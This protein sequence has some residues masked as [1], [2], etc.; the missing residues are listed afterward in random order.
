MTLCIRPH[1]PMA[2][3]QGDM[4]L[5]LC[6]PAVPV[7]LGSVAKVMAQRLSRVAGV[8]SLASVGV[9]VATDCA[10]NRLLTEPRIGDAIEFRRS[11]GKVFQSSISGI[12]TV[13]GD[14][15]NVPFDF[16]LPRGAAKEDVGTGDEIWL[17]A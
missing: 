17:L 6:Y 3:R 4:T 7:I 13:C 2:H 5:N 16:T 9:I 10:Y 1:Q 12:L 14:N 15:P 11:D 8:F